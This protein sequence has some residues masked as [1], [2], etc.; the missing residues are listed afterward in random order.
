MAHL[1][2]RW[3]ISR[4]VVGSSPLAT[5]A[6]GCS[7]RG[8]PSR[9]GGGFGGPGGSGSS[10][11]FSGGTAFTS[12]ILRFTQQA[13]TGGVT[14][15]TAAKTA[16]GNLP[17]DLAPARLP[18]SPKIGPSGRPGTPPYACCGANALCPQEHR[19]IL[20]HSSIEAAMWQRFVKEII[21]GI[22]KELA[23]CCKEVFGP[24]DAPQ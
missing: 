19:L 14:S 10:G 9:P 15:A 17:P 16:V 12:S 20:S 24:L 7:E 18:L 8:R 3:H 6:P 11:W 23:S 21:E 22:G 4:I 5:F 13:W 2:E 1:F